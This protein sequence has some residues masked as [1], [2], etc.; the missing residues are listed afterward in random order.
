MM[1]AYSDNPT[2]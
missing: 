2:N 1:N